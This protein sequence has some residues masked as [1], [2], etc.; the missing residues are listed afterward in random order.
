MR[1]TPFS[2]PVRSADR[3]DVRSFSSRSSMQNTVFAQT[4]EPTVL[5]LVI[6]FPCTRLSDSC[7]VLVSSSLNHSHSPRT[8]VVASKTC[9]CMGRRTGHRSKKNSR[10]ILNIGRVVAL[11]MRNR[12]PFFSLLRMVLRRGGACD[13]TYLMTCYSGSLSS[14]S[15]SR[16]SACA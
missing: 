4:S 15:S 2:R 14:P 12:L 3:S 7:S 1:G 6:G 10:R 9:I 13:P 11:E 16:A 5:F 8:R